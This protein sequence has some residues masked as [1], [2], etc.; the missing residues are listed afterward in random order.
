M[1]VDFLIIYAF[2]QALNRL[3]LSMHE[4]VFRKLH[5]LAENPGHP[6]LNTHRLQSAKANIWDCYITQSV[7]LLYEIKEGNLHL[8]DLGPHSIVDNVHLRGLAANTR[9]RR[10]EITPETAVTSDT[11][12]EPKNRV[13]ET[14]SIRHTV[15]A[16]PILSQKGTPSLCPI[17][18]CPSACTWGAF[19]SGTACQK[20]LIARRCP[21]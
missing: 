17:P 6:S 3:T 2:E 10:M 18:E 14:P 21:S 12:E 20:S 5:L 4:N 1:I 16:T 13:F 19:V 9:F 7:R 8:W 11:L 15:P